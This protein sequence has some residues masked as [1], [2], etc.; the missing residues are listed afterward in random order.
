M[1]KSCGS[2][3]TAST[4]P[5]N[6]GSASAVLPNPASISIM[7]G[8]NTSYPSPPLDTIKSCRGP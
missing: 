3:K 4:L 2:T 7:G 6:I 8:L 5:D 1:S